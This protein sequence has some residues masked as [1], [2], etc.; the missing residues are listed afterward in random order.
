MTEEILYCPK[1]KRRESF[2]IREK[3]LCL[4]CETEIADI[5]EARC[6]AV[7]DCMF[8]MLGKVSNGV[9]K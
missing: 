5:T 3:V 9:D 8:E 1:C 4:A 6:K 2:E 7:H